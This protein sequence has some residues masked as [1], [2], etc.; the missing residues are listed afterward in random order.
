M[1]RAGIGACDFMDGV[2]VAAI[3]YLH[4]MMRADFGYGVLSGPCGR[5]RVNNWQ[6]RH[7]CNRR[8]FH[9]CGF[10][11]MLLDVPETCCPLFSKPILYT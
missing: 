3:A 9:E 7:G 5:M 1:F 6:I 2:A 10:Y 4:P 11:P 8:C